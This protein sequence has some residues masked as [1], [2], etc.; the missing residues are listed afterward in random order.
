M[1]PRQNLV[2]TCLAATAAL[3]AAGCASQTP[4]AKQTPDDV[5][6]GMIALTAADFQDTDANRWRDTTTVAA[7]IY[8]ASGAYPLPMRVRGTFEFRLEG[9]GGK[10]LGRWVFDERQTEAALRQ[11]APGPGFVFQLSLAKL[12]AEQTQEREA[13]ILCTFTPVGGTPIRAR[14]S[15]PLLIGPMN[16]EGGSGG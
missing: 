10:N 13:E 15:A 16:R 9:K 2:R 4:H 7:Y 5:K 8:A 11:L 12:G 6:P 3:A 1:S 14:P